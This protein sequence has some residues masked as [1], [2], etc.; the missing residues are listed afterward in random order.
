MDRFVCLDFRNDFIR[1]GGFS[2]VERDRVKGD[3]VIEIGGGLLLVAFIL[4]L[5][6]GISVDP[7]GRVIAPVA[8]F[9]LSILGFILVGVG[10][11]MR[12]NEA[13]KD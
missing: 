2:N 6:G 1:A 13:Q 3:R 8:F 7:L 4:F 5:F 11:W 10:A 9:G 12:K